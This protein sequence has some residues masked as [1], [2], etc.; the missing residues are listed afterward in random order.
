M[1]HAFFKALLFLGAGAVIHA[2]HHE[3]D[4]R[5]M[6]GL[7]G[8]LPLTFATMLIGTFA[9]A[10]VPPLAGF[11]SKDEILFEA[12]L[13]AHGRFPWVW[14]AGFMAAA[15]TAFYMMR[16]LV[17]TFLGKSRASAEIRA[18]IHEPP[19]T[20][21]LPLVVLAVL[22]IGGGWLGWPHAMGGGAWLQDWL[23]PVLAGGHAHG[24]GPQEIKLEISL[25]VLSSLVALA[26]LSC[27]YFVYVRRPRI[28]Q[29]AG[30]LL[31]GLPHRLISRKY[32]VDE[33]FAAVLYRPLERL[34][35]VVFF[36][37][38]DRALIDGM[39]VNGAAL[40]ALVAGS[41]LRLMQNGM[42]RFYAWVFA[43]G[44]AIFAVY[45]TLQG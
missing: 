26:G 32:Y 20:M 39:L 19:V 41:V 12:F 10:G 28:A 6:G 34:A 5:A 37:W 25:A 42:I 18:R 22:S 8:K 2:M 44:A 1:T 27:G 36:R 23:A 7:K 16:L 29:A 9:I 24:H 3:Q 15:L 38:V 17:M 45:L 4:M 14:L 13:G 33:I 31:R 30:R 43:A 21:T 35:H 11:V 40:L